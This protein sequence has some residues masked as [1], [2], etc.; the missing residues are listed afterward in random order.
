MPDLNNQSKGI[1]I[2]KDEIPTTLLEISFDDE[3]ED[4]Y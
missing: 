1:D 2:N 4:N 3:E